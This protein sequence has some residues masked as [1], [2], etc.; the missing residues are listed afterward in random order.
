MP[1]S[2]AKNSSV[3]SMQPVQAPGDAKYI[4]MLPPVP[5]HMNVYAAAM[6]CANVSEASG[7][8]LFCF[9]RTSDSSADVP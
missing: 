1:S 5:R 3:P 8:R 6:S 9:T 7:D 2:M 4:L